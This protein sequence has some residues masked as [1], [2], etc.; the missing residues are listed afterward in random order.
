M[1]TNEENGREIRP[2]RIGNVEFRVSK[3]LGLNPRDYIDIVF[4]YP[5]PDYGQEDQ[6]EKIDGESFSTLTNH[7]YNEQNILVSFKDQPGDLME[8]EYF[9][10]YKTP[11]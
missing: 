9:T 11:I 7:Y 6:Y 2:T 8:E 4:W 1:K 5:N 3:T 10:K